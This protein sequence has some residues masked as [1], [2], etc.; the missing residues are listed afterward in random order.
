MRWICLDPGDKRTGVAISSPEGTFAIPVMV[1]E[2]DRRGASAARIEELLTEHGAGGLLIGLPLRMNG[3]HSTQ[4][5]AAL[6]FAFRIAAHFGTVP[7]PPPGIDL[8][9][10]AHAY[11]ERDACREHRRPVVR[12]QLWDER[13][14]SWDAQRS[15]NSGAREGRTRRD[16]RPALDA[17]A[18]TIILQSYL[19]ASAAG[20]SYQQDSSTSDASSSDSRD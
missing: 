19:D 17:H 2:H 10:I 6:S 4:T 11:T 5:S 1:L 9:G 3:S 15:V 8:S 13:L 16:R 7:E 18:A 14:S 20:A 12:V